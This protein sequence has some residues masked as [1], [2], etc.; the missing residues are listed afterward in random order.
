MSISLA[1]EVLQTEANGI[2]AM[3]DRLDRNFDQA[4]SLIMACPSRVI[5]TGIGK[6]GIIGQKIAATLNST[7]TSSFFLHPVEAMHGDLGIVAADDV[8]LAISNSGETPELNMLLPNFKK[9]GNQIIAMT[10]NLSSTL[11]R[12][13]DAV[14]DVGVER[15][16]CP[17][18]LA[19]TSSTTAT[20]AMGDALA[21]VL[22][23]LKQFKESDFLRNHPGGSL[24]DRLKVKVEEVM[25]TGARIPMV[26]SETPFIE[27]LAELN[28][29][30]IGAVLVVSDEKN[31]LG[32]LTDGDVRRLVVK[33]S[34]I[35][36]RPV[37]EVMTANPKTI[38]ADLLAADALSIMQ[39]HEVT[40]LAVVNHD[41]QL[42]GI[43]HLHDLLGKGEFRVLI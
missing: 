5:I 2:L 42:V 4:I 10:G 17:L 15:E 22:L 31:I 27:A 35:F 39:R 28:Q 37:G 20:L 21:V 16:A 32:I 7:G 1:Q 24:G 13:A 12:T 43:L 18:G 36:Q 9:R 41:Q 19:P 33:S 25:L 8:I 38:C 29:K 3:K 14:L 30:N 40:I 34:A 6:S 23:N 11:A 26:P